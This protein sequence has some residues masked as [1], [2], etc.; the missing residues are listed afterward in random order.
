MKGLRENQAGLSLAE[1]LVAVMLSMLILVMVTSFFIQVGKIT[2]N[3]GQQRDANRNAA[4]ISNEVTS[5]LRVASTLPKLNS[6]SPDPAIVDGTRSSLT[7][8]ALSNTTATKPAP[9][10]ITFT[11]DG[12]GKVTETRCTGTANG[13]YYT[14]G[15][16]ASTSTRTLGTNV[17]APSGTSD[18][19]FTYLDVNGTA[20]AIGTG[21]LSATQRAAV[22]SIIVTVR[23]QATNSAA[24]PV[25]VSSTV[26]LRN[27]GLDTGTI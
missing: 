16:C 6:A 18:Q 4:N 23:T 19:L 11:L 22:A 25:I 14:F 3:A 17:L 1:I 21:S 27:I 15:S 13:N 26:V 24:R 12:T 8:Y 5:V 10:K 9:V 20:M 7:L 2:T